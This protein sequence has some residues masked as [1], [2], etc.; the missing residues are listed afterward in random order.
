MK[1]RDF[2]GLMGSV[3][4]TPHSASAQSAKRTYRVPRSV[5]STKRFIRSPAAVKNQR[6]DN[7][8]K[9]DVFTQPGSL[10]SI[11]PGPPHVRF[12]PKSRP[13]SGHRGRSF[14]C[15][16]ATYAPQQEGYRRSRASA[17][18]P[19]STSTNSAMILSPSASATRVTAAR[20]AS[21]PNP[22]PVGER[23]R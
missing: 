21:I 20:C 1:R 10:A 2:L 19:V 17:P 6:C 16:R 22:S 15:Q 9:R 13:L 11:S 23:L 8:M 5:P 4:I 18:L 12:P 7:H 14:P 3:A